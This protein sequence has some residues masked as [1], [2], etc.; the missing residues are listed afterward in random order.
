MQ[1][2]CPQCGKLL[3]APT[4]LPSL[5]KCP[6]CGSVF[7]PSP[8]PVPPPVPVTPYSPPTATFPTAAPAGA[9]VDAVRGPAIAL[10]IVGGLN[11]AWAIVDLASRIFMFSRL[12]AG[13]APPPMPPPFQNVQVTPAAIIGGIAFDVVWL[14]AG[15]LVIYGAFR[16]LRLRS[17]GLAITSTVVSMIP[18][19][20]CCCFLGIPFG[21]WGLM[22]LN[23]PDVRSSFE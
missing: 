3:E 11:L 20:T 15:F 2:A 17:Y 16:M 8:A 4:P 13:Q 10:I 18:G 1:I 14:I 23:R 22:V 6:Y 12:Q 5:A 9:A 7:T 21:I 19:V